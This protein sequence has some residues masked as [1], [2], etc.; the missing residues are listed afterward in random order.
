[1][2]APEID[3]ADAPRPDSEGQKRKKHKKDK[4][5]SAWISFAGRIVAQIVGAIAT[6]ALGVTVLH[7]YKGEATDHR[8]AGT[9]SVAV[10]PIEDFSAAA[11]DDHTAD[12]MT[13]MVIANLAKVPGLRVASRTSSMHF[14]GQRQPLRQM[15]RELEARW[16]VEGSIVRSG[17]RIRI[18]AQLIDA[19]SDYHAWAETYDRPTGDLLTTQAEVASAI[20]RAVTAVLPGLD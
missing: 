10:L 12:G 4:M 8:P 11:A 9:R 5:R 7:Q 14:K 13:E 19:G 20:T 3:A 2:N 1:M 6:V 17:A 16:I 15:A 18:T